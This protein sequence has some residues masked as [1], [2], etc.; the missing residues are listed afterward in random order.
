MKRNAFL[1]LGTAELELS[2]GIFPKGTVHLFRDVTFRN[3]LLPR[4]VEG[5]TLYSAFAIQP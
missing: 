5:Y 1:P 4:S 2:Q 3:E